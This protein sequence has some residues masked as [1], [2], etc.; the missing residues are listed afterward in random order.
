MYHVSYRYFPGSIGIWKGHKQTPGGTAD[1]Y[2]P[3]RSSY[4]EVP[5][6]L[7]AIHVML[8]N[9]NDTSGDECIQRI[10]TVRIHP[11]AYR[12]PCINQT[13]VSIACILDFTRSLEAKKA[14]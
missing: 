11:G 7:A 14:M 4:I 9:L 10:L 12:R 6:Q 2:L 3:R 13:V 5:V 1:N 8:P